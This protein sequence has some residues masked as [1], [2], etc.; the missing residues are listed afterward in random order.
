MMKRSYVLSLILMLS[1]IL[2]LSATVGCDGISDQPSDTTAETGADDG[3]LTY[4]IK[5]TDYMGDALDASILIEVFK[6]EESVVMKKL[7]SDGTVSFEL[8]RGEYT[9][10]P[11]ASSGEY[12]FDESA[13]VLS[14]DKPS[15]EIQMYAV[16]TRN[17]TIYPP[18]DGERSPYEAKI[19][20]EGATYVEID[21]SE[22]SYY[23]FTPT[24][25]GIYRIGFIGGDDISIGSYGEAN[26]VHEY[27]VAVVEGNAYE[28]EVMNS[29]IGSGSGGTLSLVIGLSSTDSR[30]AIIFI[31]RISDPTPILPWTFIE[32]Q[33]IRDEFIHSDILNNKIV[34]ISVTDPNVKFIKGT[35]GYYHYGSADGPV[36]F[37]R[38]S[39]ATRYLQSFTEICETAL[40]CRYFYDESGELVRKE[41]YNDLINKYA[42]VCDGNGAVPLT[43]ELVNAVVNT[44]EQMGWWN[45]GQNKMDIFTYD[46]E[47]VVT[48]VNQGNI[49]KGNE[50]MFAC[51]YAE[52]FVKGSEDNPIALTPSDTRIFRATI[53]SEGAV[54]F[55]ASAASSTLTVKNAEGLIVR[56]NG[57]EYN[58]NED[59]VLTLNIIDGET[60]FSIV[61]N[62][63]TEFE[64][65][66]KLNKTEQ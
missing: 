30:D 13:C 2:C 28:I 59:G 37:I 52:E 17:H 8:E 7:G 29:S 14:P 62:V 35:D 58:A 34:D 53:P 5:L 11:K 23:L 26:I 61:G 57:A 9:F 27:N 51:F 33:E 10:I 47:G 45:F 6:G 66:F 63:D 38:I 60:S 31:E 50:W 56:Y 42:E 3:M 46:L 22:M 16:S 64:F 55:T 18:V 1:L 21:R 15:A 39:S 12:H 20:D 24:R 43:D 32:P 54:Y 4:S 44:G 65:E 40:M 19:L 48:G 49:V 25:G 41:G 36:V